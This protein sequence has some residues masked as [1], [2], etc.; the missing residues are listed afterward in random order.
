MRPART[1]DRGLTWHADVC[2][3]PDGRDGNRA[4]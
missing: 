4:P 3:G 2:H 1:R